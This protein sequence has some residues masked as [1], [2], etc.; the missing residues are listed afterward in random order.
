MHLKKPVAMGC[1]FVIFV[2]HNVS[3]ASFGGGSHEVPGVTLNVMSP[4]LINDYV[5]GLP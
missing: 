3:N 1:S 2:V 4:K 5:L